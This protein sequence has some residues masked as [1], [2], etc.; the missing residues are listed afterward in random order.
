ML[1]VDVADVAKTR[2]SGVDMSLL[3]TCHCHGNMLWC[4]AGIAK[5]DG[6]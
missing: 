4:G 2:W 1:K 6:V 3:L 5:Y